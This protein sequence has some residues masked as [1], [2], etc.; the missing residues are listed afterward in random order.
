MKPGMSA[1]SHS[2]FAPLL[3][4]KAHQT[5]PDHP[6]TEWGCQMRNQI[7][8]NFEWKLEQNR[9]ISAAVSKEQERSSS[10][11]DAHLDTKSCQSLTS[12]FCKLQAVLQWCLVHFY[13][14]FWYYS[15][16]SAFGS[17]IKVLSITEDMICLQNT[18]GQWRFL[19]GKAQKKKNCREERSLSSTMCL[20]H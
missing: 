4:S 6:F 19:F 20:N 5:L 8:K 1:K 2:L 11:C 9:A 13:D 15:Y 14:H 17:R 12:E 10:F 18:H 7:K 3:V 16:F